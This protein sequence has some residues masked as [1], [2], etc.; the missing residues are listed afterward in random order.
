[1]L[2]FLFSLFYARFSL[3][4]GKAPYR[5]VHTGPAADRYADQPLPGGT[6]KVDRRRSI[7][8]EIDRRRSIEEEKGKKRRGK[9]ERRSTSPP[10]SPAHCSRTLAARGSPASRRRPQVARGQLLSPRGETKLRR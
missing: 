6:A 2:R 8:G 4:S 3:P 5:P 10:S 9:E 1:M 7:D